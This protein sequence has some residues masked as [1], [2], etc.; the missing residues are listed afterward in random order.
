MEKE[1][2]VMKKELI[3]NEKKRINKLVELAYKHDPRI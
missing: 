2:M 1:N 3:K